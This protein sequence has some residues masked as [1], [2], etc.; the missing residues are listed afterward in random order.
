MALSSVSVVMSSLHLT[1]TGRQNLFVAPERGRE[2]SRAPSKSRRARRGGA[3]AR[4]R[5]GTPT[6]DGEA[7]T[8]SA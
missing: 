3:G 6:P 1:G 5:A 8:S 2:A 7:G 4:R